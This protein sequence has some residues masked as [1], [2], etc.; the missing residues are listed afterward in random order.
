MRHAKPCQCRN[1]IYIC[2]RG[3]L[4]FSN[5]PAMKSATGPSGQP[6]QR[7]Y[8][9]E[10]CS[11]LVLSGRA[12]AGAFGLHDAGSATADRA[13]SALQFHRTD[14]PGRSALA[15][16]RLVER[17]WQ[18]RTEWPDRHGTTGQSRSRRRYRAGIAGQ[19]SGRNRRL[20][21]VAADWRFGRCESHQDFPQREPLSP[22][23]SRRQEHVE[24]LQS[25]R[26]CELGARYLGEGAGQFALGR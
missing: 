23:I 7:V 9:H 21:I 6:S 24:L 13:E 4:V 5:P 3:D 8:F 10:E 15:E 25:Y 2:A 19:S 22:R 16:G 1:R 17:L 11:S 12:H 26:R 20:S 14:H 18:R